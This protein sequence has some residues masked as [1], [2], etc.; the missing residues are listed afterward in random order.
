MQMGAAASS[1]SSSGHTRAHF[2]APLGAAPGATQG[3]RSTALTWQHNG[4]A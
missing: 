3:R 4:L 2:V 1:F